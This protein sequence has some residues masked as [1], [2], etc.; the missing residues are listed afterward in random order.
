MTADR[1]GCPDAVA[2]LPRPAFP[3]TVSG[4]DSDRA[5]DMADREGFT[6]VSFTSVPERA[7]DRLK[8]IARAR[9]EF[10][11][12]LFSEAVRQLLRDRRAGAVAYLASRKGGVR[13]SLWLE[14]DLVA[15][16][17]E[18]AAEDQ[19]SKTV[20]FLTALKRFAEREKLDVEL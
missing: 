12:D 14:E 2:K 13:R 8:D 11:R 1:R 10:P 6:S 7:F 4:I 16:M 20:L 19:V 18:A 9:R 3:G 17:A 15:E 5:G